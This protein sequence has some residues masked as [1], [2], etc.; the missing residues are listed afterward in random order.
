MLTL[1][2]YGYLVHTAMISSIT[3]TA[4]SGD[5]VRLLHY[6]AVLLPTVTCMEVCREIAKTR[7]NTIIC[8]AQKNLGSQRFARL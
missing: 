2:Q 1:L 7:T 5:M 4:L 6:A 3:A 8:T